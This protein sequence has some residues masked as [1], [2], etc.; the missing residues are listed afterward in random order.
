MTQNKSKDIK[1]ANILAIFFKIF[2]NAFIFLI[3][4][5]YK[6]KYAIMHSHVVQPFQ[7]L[8]TLVPTSKTDVK[9]ACYYKIS[10]SDIA[11][12]KNCHY[13]C[14]AKKPRWRNR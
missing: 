6:Y 12:E 14:T 11:Q 13:L 2:H 10:R 7:P 4:I 8:S 9:I 5:T 1:I 3:F